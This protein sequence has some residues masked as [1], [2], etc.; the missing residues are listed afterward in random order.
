MIP[1][2]LLTPGRVGNSPCP[3]PTGEKQTMLKTVLTTIAAIL[4]IIIPYIVL[5]FIVGGAIGFIVEN[6]WIYTLKAA[7]FLLHAY[8]LPAC[9]ILIVMCLFLIYLRALAEIG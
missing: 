7:A 9:I 5:V 2:P 8:G 4:V 6:L 1:N 3:A